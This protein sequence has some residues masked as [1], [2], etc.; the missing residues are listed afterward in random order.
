MK[1]RIILF[2]NFEIISGEN[3][4][5]EIDTPRQQEFLTFL[6]LNRD[7]AI[8]RRQLSYLIWLDS[9]EKQ[10]KA[11][12]RNLLHTVRKNLPDAD[13]FI[14]VDHNSIK[15]MNAKGVELDVEE[16][17]TSIENARI[18]KKNNNLNEQEYE[19]KNSIAL[20]NGQLVPNC[21][22][23]WIEDYRSNYKQSYL[24]ALKALISLLESKREYKEA[25]HFSNK[26]IK[27][28]PYDEKAWRMLIKLYSLNNDRVKAIRCYEDCLETLRDELNIEP[29]DETKELYEQILKNNQFVTDG[30]AAQIPK[31]MSKG[32]AD[33][34]Q[35]NINDDKF[36]TSSEILGK[37]ISSKRSGFF[38]SFGLLPGKNAKY[39]D[40]LNNPF[41]WLQALSEKRLLFYALLLMS[42]TTFLVIWIVKAQPNQ[43]PPVKES[44][45]TIAILPLNVLSDGQ[46]DMRFTQGFTAT[47]NNNL[48]RVQNFRVISYN[49]VDYYSKNF[50]QARLISDLSLDYLI[51]GSVQ[52]VEDKVRVN[53]Q[54]LNTK[55]NVYILSESYMRL[56]GDVLILQNHIAQDIVGR[57]DSAFQKADQLNLPEAEEIDPKA[58]LLYSEGLEEMHK[59][60]ILG[61]QQSLNLYK[62]S[63]SIDSSF[64]PVYSSL[65]FTYI[66]LELMI[67]EVDYKNEITT[68]INK[69]L[70]IDPNSSMA[71]VARGMYQHLYAYEWDLADESFR[72]SIE[73][74]ESFDIAHHE[75][76][77]F[78][79]RWGNFEKAL[80]HERT[81]LSLNPISP[82]FQS[83]IGEILLYK[84]D[85]ESAIVELKKALSIDP[86]FTVANYWLTRAY[87]HNQEY[88]KALEANNNFSYPVRNNYKAEILAYM[89]KKREALDLLTEL[90]NDYER[91]PYKAILAEV[92]YSTYIALEEKQEALDWFV[93]AYQH[94]QGWLSYIKVNPNLDFIREEPEF[95]EIES[96]IFPD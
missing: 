11:N 47:L 65:A 64:A 63:I 90:K 72:K 91:Y 2:G 67:T 58:F 59:K 10:A 51:E 21:Y 77:H 88:V 13:Q 7:R 17:E 84:R 25:I 27:T 74:N 86:T 36:K 80:H 89:G 23:E 83:G 35:A 46:T 20:Y 93:K 56:L 61:F 29:T 39:N 96:E 71:Y 50:E 85:Y 32:K 82:D 31:L 3:S 45:D 92:I 41:G 24:E 22:S 44:K 8:T 40:L 33:V 76:A 49:T 55:T 62:Q 53:I 78:L 1:L 18:A 48:A 9:S 57:I 16:F 79:M 4:I 26:F 54:V 95:K 87:I 42:V 52:I 60:D 5:G 37:E 94:K 15:W 43:T 73:L 69:A 66:L 30:N 81:A 38:E 34:S 14:K 19:L 68:A 12:L 28:E 70:E 6:L 75:Y